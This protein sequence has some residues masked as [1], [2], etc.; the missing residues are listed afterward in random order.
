[1]AVCGFSLYVIQ[2]NYLCDKCLLGDT[3]ASPTVGLF[4]KKIEQYVV[5]YNIHAVESSVLK[6]TPF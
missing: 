5:M 4:G 2:H 3:A 1:M 6:G